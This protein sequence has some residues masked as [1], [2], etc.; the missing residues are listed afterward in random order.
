VI[1][2]LKLVHTG[3]SVGTRPLRSDA[4]FSRGISTPSC[5][6]V[7]PP[8]GGARSAASPRES[9]AE[10]L[11]LLTF[12]LGNARVS[13]DRVQKKIVCGPKTAPGGKKTL[14][15]PRIC[16]VSRRQTIRTGRILPLGACEASAPRGP[17]HRRRAEGSRPR[18]RALPLPRR[19]G[20]ADA[21]AR[22]TAPPPCATQAR[23]QGRSSPRSECPP[24]L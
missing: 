23:F 16:S 20:G 6:Q 11:S 14:Q 9:A 19:S 12:T 15:T 4:G 10:F 18:P 3:L 8:R 2:E 5:A 13:G 21:R 7:R 17:D 22:A 24:G 1:D